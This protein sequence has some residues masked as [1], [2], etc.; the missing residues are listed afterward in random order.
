MILET[1]YHLIQVQSIAEGEHSAILLTFIKLTCVIKI[2]VL[3][4]FKWS[5]KTGFTVCINFCLSLYLQPYIAYYGSE[6]SD[7]S[8]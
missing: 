1:N 2:F 3:S 6:G 5:F 4:T 7:E 8:V